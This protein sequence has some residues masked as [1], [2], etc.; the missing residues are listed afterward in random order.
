VQ[1]PSAQEKVIGR[2]GGFLGVGPGRLVQTQL[3]GTDDS[4]KT[5]QNLHIDGPAR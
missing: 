2:V 5:S 3:I 4:V 1:V